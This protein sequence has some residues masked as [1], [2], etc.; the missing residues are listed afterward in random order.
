[1]ILVT[2]ATGNVGR[3]V[4]DQ[5]LA[6]DRKVRIFTRNAAKAGRWSD[7]AQIATGDFTEPETFASAIAGARAAFLMNGGLDDGVFRRLVA[8]AAEQGVSR[9]VFLSSQTA[10]DPSSLIGE[11]HRRKE[12]ALLSSGLEAA[13]IRAGGFMSNTNQWV[14]SIKSQG[15]VYDPTGNGS[16]ASVHPADIAAVA[17]HALIAPKLTETIFEVTGDQPLTTAEKVDVLARVLGRQLRIVEVPA[18]TAAQELVKNGIPPHVA[19]AVGESFA[20]IRDGQA[21]SITDTVERVTGRKP[22][23]FESW[24]REHAAQFA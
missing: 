8:I 3:E 15:I 12:E 17:V 23:S 7:R 18:E 22:R 9:V 21:A 11:L 19:R 2:G 14:S 16:I 6:Q 13:I 20:A 24:V 1:M 5:L 4:V 10:A